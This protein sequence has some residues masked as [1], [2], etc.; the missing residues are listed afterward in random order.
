ML[1]KMARFAKTPTSTYDFIYLIFLD[2]G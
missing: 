1:Q 2:G